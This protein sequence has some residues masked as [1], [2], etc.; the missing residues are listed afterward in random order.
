MAIPDWGGCVF[1][2]KKRRAR[3]EG[4]PKNILAAA[5]SCSLG[6]RFAMVVDTDINIYSADDL[7]WA[8]A[9]RTDA[10]EGICIVAPGGMG[11]TFQPAERSSAGDKDWTQSNIKFTG[12][13]GID[14]TVPYR[15]TDAF[16]RASYP[17]DKVKLSDWFN[18]AEIKKSQSYQEAYAKFFAESGI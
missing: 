6:A 11:Q 13:I 17:V 5:L 14:A 18:E 12:A 9:T 10:K 4:Y 8:L 3:D 16:D 7:M 2:V 1:Q 15:Y